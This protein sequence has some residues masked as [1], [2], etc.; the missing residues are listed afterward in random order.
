MRLTE[1]RALGPS[2]Q[3]GGDVCI[4]ARVRQCGNV[5]PGE[6]PAIGEYPFEA[7]VQSIRGQHD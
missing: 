2:P 7:L 6:S 5:L 4:H 3:T 1:V